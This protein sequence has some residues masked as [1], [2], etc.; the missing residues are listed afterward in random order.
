VQSDSRRAR[1]KLTDPQRLVDGFD[2]EVTLPFE[3][4]LRI[5]STHLAPGEVA[6]RIITH[7]SLPVA[8]A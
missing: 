5:D 6:G 4:R 7:Y 3:P 8:P 2:L 1:G